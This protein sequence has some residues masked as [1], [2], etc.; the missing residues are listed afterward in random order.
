[1]LLLAGRPNFLPYN[2]DG[3][4]V[5]ICAENNVDNRDVFVGGE[6]G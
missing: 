6:Q 4:V 2:L 5:W 3:A 1:M